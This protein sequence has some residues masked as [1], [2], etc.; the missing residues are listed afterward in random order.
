MASCHF[1]FSF[2]FYM[3]MNAKVAL[4]QSQRATFTADAINHKK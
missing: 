1:G 2:N 4:W 3:S